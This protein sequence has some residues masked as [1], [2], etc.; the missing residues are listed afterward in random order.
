[1]VSVRA[2]GGTACSQMRLKS[3]TCLTT[4]AVERRGQRERNTS[5]RAR[6]GMST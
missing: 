3:E 5:G 2:A 6:E 1:M 4:E